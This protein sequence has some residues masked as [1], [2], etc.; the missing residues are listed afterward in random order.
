[1]N[2]IL[3]AILLCGIMTDS[4]YGATMCSQSGTTTIVLDPTINGNGSSYNT[5]YSTWWTAFPYGTISGISAC[6]SSNYGQSM[7]GY[8]SKLTDTNPD[9]GVTSRVV[10]G[11]TNG[12]YCWCKMTHPAVSKWAFYNNYG[13]ASNCAARCANGCGYYVQVNSG[14]RAGLFGSVAN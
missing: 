4:V 3:I 11:E 7:G 2:K 1:M 13:S 8:I 9:T 12:K 5:T 6:L 14:L 10:G